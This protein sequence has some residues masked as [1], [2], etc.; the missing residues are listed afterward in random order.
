MARVNCQP[1]F[2][3]PRCRLLRSPATAL[4][5]PKGFLNAFA[6]ALGDGIAG[7]T[8]RALSGIVRLVPALLDKPGSIH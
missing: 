2:G 7:M 8:G 1:T 5:Q 6:N 3:N 4:A